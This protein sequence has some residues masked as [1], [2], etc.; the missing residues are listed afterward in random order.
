MPTQTRGN[1]W[2]GW[3]AFCGIP[4]TLLALGIA[5]PLGLLIGGATIVAFIVGKN[6]EAEADANAAIDNARA[7]TPPTPSKS[8]IDDDEY[9]S[10]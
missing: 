2:L 5:W 6:V 7:T 9:V 1:G 8:T 3:A 4:A 10:W